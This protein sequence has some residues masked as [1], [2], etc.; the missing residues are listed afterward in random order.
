YF[1]SR[2][3]DGIRD[4]HVTGVQTCALPIWRSPARIQRCATSTA[5]STLPLE[6]SAQCIWSQR[7]GASFHGHS[8]LP[9]AARADVRSARGAQKD[10]TSVVQAETR[11]DGTLRRRS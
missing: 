7:R 10:G 4:F 11:G 1:S 6:K 9:S 3:E 8:P 2:A 5:A